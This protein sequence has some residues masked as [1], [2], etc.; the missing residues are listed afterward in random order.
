[1]FKCGI[2]NF[3][4]DSWDEW[5]KH[6]SEK[7]HTWIKQKGICNYCGVPTEYTYMGKIVNQ[8]KPAICDDCK[9]LISISITNMINSNSDY[10]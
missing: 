8:T 9:N 10:N 6:E 5:E 7:S 1:M 3:E 2:H 4:T